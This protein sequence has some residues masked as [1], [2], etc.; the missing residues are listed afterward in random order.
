M[1]TAGESY[2]YRQLEEALVITKDIYLKVFTSGPKNAY[3]LKSFFSEY[4]K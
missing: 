2:Y 4:A 1:D 3:E